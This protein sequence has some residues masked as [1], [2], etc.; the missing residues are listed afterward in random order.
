MPRITVTVSHAVAQKIDYV[1]KEQT[2]DR[3]DSAL[4][5]RAVIEYLMRFPDP[6]R[7]QLHLPIDAI[8]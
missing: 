4:V 6:P 5:N 7:D 3:S 1:R 2:F 8:G